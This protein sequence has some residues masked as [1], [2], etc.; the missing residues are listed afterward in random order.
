MV[1]YVKEKRKEIFRSGL[2]FLQQKYLFVKFCVPK[3]PQTALFWLVPKLLPRGG[4]GSTITCSYFRKIIFLFAKSDDK[5][6]LFCESKN[7]TKLSQKYYCFIT[8]FKTSAVD[9]AR[10]VRNTLI[11]AHK[12]TVSLYQQ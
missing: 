6:M 8:S 10:E 9:G 12:G 4:S 1:N 2:K 5:I 11:K 3:P 7:F